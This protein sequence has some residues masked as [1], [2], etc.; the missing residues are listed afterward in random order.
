MDSGRLEVF[1][2]EGDTM[3]AGIEYGNDEAWYAA[4]IHEATWLNHAA[5]TRAKYLQN[6]MEE[7]FDAFAVRC[8]HAR[9]S[10]TSSGFKSSS[11]IG[12]R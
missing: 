1:P 4:L 12:L 10:V 2:T 6:A 8:V 7:E 9:P 5:P 3:Q 11:A